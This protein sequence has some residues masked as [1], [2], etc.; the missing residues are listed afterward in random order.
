MFQITHIHTQCVRQLHSR[1]YRDISHALKSLNIVIEVN[2]E[3]FSVGYCLYGYFAHH[4]C[5]FVRAVKYVGIQ[6][7]SNIIM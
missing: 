5:H 2:L 4:I 6:F 3:I 7:I 1:I